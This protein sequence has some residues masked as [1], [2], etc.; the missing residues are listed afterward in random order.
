M[1]SSVV[2][3]VLVVCGLVG[4][5]PGPELQARVDKL[6]QDNDVLAKSR[7]AFSAGLSSNME[8]ETTGPF[9]VDTVLKFQRVVTN[10]GNG[11][12]PETGIFTAPVKGLYFVHLTGMAGSSGEL[13]AGVKK[14][15]ENMF[16]IYQKSG[17]QASASNAMTLALEPGNRLSVHL[18]TG[19]T[20][21]GHGRLTTFTV[22]L[23]FPL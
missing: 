15:T 2:L 8:W 4:A 9:D 19:N 6:E 16:S 12:D 13:N 17:T 3:V 11:Y 1:V 7:V 20:I 10:I 21:V 5:R 22:V 18:W 14:D 23:L